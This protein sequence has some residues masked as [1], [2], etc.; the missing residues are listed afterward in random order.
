[1]LLSKGDRGGVGQLGGFFQSGEVRFFI[2]A[3]HDRGSVFGRL[4]QKFLGSRFPLAQ[5]GQA[6]LEAFIRKHCAKETK[7]EWGLSD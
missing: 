1:M 6:K 3:R 4:C 7:K 2:L 5:L